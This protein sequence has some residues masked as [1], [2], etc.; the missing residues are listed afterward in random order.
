MR[1]KQPR[2]PAKAFMA[3]ISDDR[4]W[5]RSAN[6]ESDVNTLL[7]SKVLS[8]LLL[9]ETSEKTVNVRTGAITGVV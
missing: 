1:S 9:R 3:M 7:V 2:E 8:P 6:S 5:A 4:G